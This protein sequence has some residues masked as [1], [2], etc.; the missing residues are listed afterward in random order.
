MT[1]AR[2]WSLSFVHRLCISMNVYRLALVHCI[3]KT[4]SGHD[5]YSIVIALENSRPSARS[6]GGKEIA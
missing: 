4:T 3:A 5:E 6:V 2:R 1:V